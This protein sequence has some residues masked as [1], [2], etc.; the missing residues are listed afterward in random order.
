MPAAAVNGCE[1]YYREQGRGPAI[2]FIHGSVTDANTWDQQVARLSPH[3]KCVTYDRRGYTRSLR[4][5]C[6]SSE[7]GL[8]ARDAAGLIGKLSMAPCLVVA[9]CIGGV[10]AI[11]LMRR[12]PELVRG[13]LLSE[14]ALF[15]LVPDEGEVLVSRASTLVR[16]AVAARGPQAAVETFVQHI[17]SEGW[18]K[19]GET[20]RKRMRANY[21]ALL[22]VLEGTGYTIEAE[23][24]AQIRVPC[25]VIRGDST[26]AAFQLVA[27][28]LAEL[29]PRSTLIELEDCG[30]HT[31]IHQPE[32]FATTVLEFASTL[33]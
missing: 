5:S 31:Y 28:H 8:H 13:A 30:H 1:L 26:P 32:A 19:T 3:F 16:E 21:A 4:G 12:F 2:L 6:V 15:S 9:S 22:T 17:D 23:E 33:D 20:E 29:L 10:V 11:E 7:P 18:A 25:A 14:P 24:I 27:P